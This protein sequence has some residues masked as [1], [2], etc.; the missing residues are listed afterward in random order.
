[1]P[2]SIFAL[3]MHVKIVIPLSDRLTAEASKIVSFQNQLYQ[4]CP[5]TTLPNQSNR[6]ISMPQES[7]AGI[8]GKR[9][10]QNQG[11]WQWQKV[12]CQKSDGA[13][14]AAPKSM[15]KTRGERKISR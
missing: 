6:K 4:L 15:A 12:E 7:V 3:S 2:N 5:N 9:L 10:T 14:Q 8:E 13:H 11:K 1:M